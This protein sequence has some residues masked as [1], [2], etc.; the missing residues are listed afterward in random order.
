MF[1]L[2]LPLVA[3]IA[4]VAGQVAPPFELEDDRGEMVKLS[5]YRGRKVVLAFFPKAFTPG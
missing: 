4:V 1:R 5:D 2:F 3:A